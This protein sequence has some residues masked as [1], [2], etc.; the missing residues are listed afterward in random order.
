MEF[1]MFANEEA[2]K[3]HREEMRGLYLKMARHENEMLLRAYKRKIKEIQSTR[4]DWLVQKH[5]N[6]A[7]AR[8][9]KKAKV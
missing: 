6:E 2:E 8:R 1:K 3:A 5:S 9:L 7:I 4:P